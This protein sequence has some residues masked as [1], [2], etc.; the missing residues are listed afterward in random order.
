MQFY[1][2]GGKRSGM[3]N[4]DACNLLADA[5]LNRSNST[6]VVPP[7][8]SFAPPPIYH[9]PD[10]RSRSRSHSRRR[11]HYYSDSSDISTPEKKKKRRDENTY[12]YSSESDDRKK[13]AIDLID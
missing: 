3:S 4:V 7:A 10:Y 2:G 6:G 8:M 9:Y 12:D 1:T 11:R 5:F 13:S